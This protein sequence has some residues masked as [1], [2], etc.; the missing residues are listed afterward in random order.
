MLAF[1]AAVAS[2]EPPSSEDYAARGKP[3]VAA[4]EHV[5][6]ISVDGLRP[7]LA[8]RANAPVMRS[9]L[10][11][12]AFSFWARTVEVSVTLPAHTSMLTGVTP[13]KHGVSWNS[14]LPERMS[15]F[16]AYPTILELAHRAGLVTE[17]IAG[18]SKF[19]TLN[20][21][22]TIDRVFVPPGTNTS[23]SNTVVT[24]QALQL[25]AQG[26]VRPALSFIHFPDVDAAGHAHGWGSPEQIAAI[27]QTDF[28]IGRILAAVDRS[29]TI[30]IVSA[31][32]GG[33]GLTHRPND[34]RSRHIPWIIAGPGVKHGFDLAQIESLEINT[35]DTAATALWLL[36]FTIPRYFDGRVVNAAFD[37]GASGH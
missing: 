29:T 26:A 18:K 15:S 12:G 4:V 27:E 31:D 32:H 5:V 1:G 33:A 35:E 3:P 11:E 28:E 22:Q 25:Y 21:P 16:P 6:I 2:P 19:R 34:P 14:D 10:Q 7:D 13:A 30:I 37:G 9:L 24:G 17:M 20:K 36:G 23:A 8:L